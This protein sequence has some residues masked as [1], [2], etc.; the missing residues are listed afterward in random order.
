PPSPSL[1]VQEN[2]SAAVQEV[3][4]AHRRIP[5]VSNVSVQG[6]RPSLSPTDYQVRFSPATT[7]PTVLRLSAESP[8]FQRT[9]AWSTLH[10]S[11]ISVPEGVQDLHIQVEVTDVVVGLPRLAGRDPDCSSQ[12][13]ELWT[14]YHGEAE[15]SE[16]L[17]SRVCANSLTCFTSYPGANGCFALVGKRSCWE[18][19]QT[20]DIGE[21]N[22]SLQG[23]DS[24]SGQ[25]PTW[26]AER[27]L[28]GRL[29][30]GRRKENETPVG[31]M[32]AV[33]AGKLAFGVVQPDWAGPAATLSFSLDLEVGGQSFE[34]DFVPITL[35]RGLPAPNDVLCLLIGEKD[36]G[37]EVLKPEGKVDSQGNAV[38]TISEYDPTV[39]K[40]LRL[41]VMP[42][43]PDPDLRANWSEWCAPSQEDQ[44]RLEQHSRCQTS[45]IIRSRYKVCGA[46]AGV[47]HG[48]PLNDEPLVVNLDPWLGRPQAQ[49]TF[50]IVH[51]DGPGHGSGSKGSAK[52]RTVAL[53]FE[54]VDGPAAWAAHHGCALLNSREAERGILASADAICSLLSSCADRLC[55]KVLVN[56]L[57]SVS[58]E[59][60]A[61]VLTCLQQ[62]APPCSQSIT[63]Q[64][65]HYSNHAVHLEGS[66][67]RIPIGT[68]MQ[69]ADKLGQGG[70]ALFREIRQKL[71][72]EN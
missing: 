46:P 27:H 68:L 2:L 24:S 12:S 15:P 39:F 10:G 43:L 1:L 50:G 65:W 42:L 52:E 16:E 69:Q 40:S 35:H 18:L 67:I 17:C 64:Q 56:S 51:R 63:E 23:A 53:H 26:R 66:G 14:T 19:P 13:A 58:A 32:V 25:L 20:R 45:D 33:E 60:T 7:L 28:R 9:V 11:V 34:T 36:A 48:R 6:L 61:K 21:V 44:K 37:S 71:A 59:Q 41:L 49:P 4:L 29:S 38:V 62:Q 8:R 31:Q 72:L 22:A 47:T 3:Q 54:G 57:P 55:E 70:L 30:G 5:R